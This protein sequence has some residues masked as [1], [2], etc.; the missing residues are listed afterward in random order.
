MR[1]GFRSLP[2]RITAAILTAGLIVSSSNLDYVR[3]VLPGVQNVSQVEAA[4]LTTGTIKDENLLKAMEVYVNYQKEKLNIAELNG[5]NLLSDGYSDYQKTITEEEARNFNGDVDL[6]GCTGI[7]ELTGIHIF[8][9]IKSINIS[10]Y[11]G[12]VISNFAFQN[13]SELNK[14]VIPNTVTSIGNFAFNNCTKL[15]TIEVKGDTVNN[16]DGILNLY[17]INIIGESAFSA[18]TKFE[19]VVFNQS[20]TGLK[21]GSN[22]FN[23]CTGLKSIYVPTKAAG[24]LG[25]GVFESCEN[26]EKATLNPDLTVIPNA[27]FHK[28]NLSKMDTFPTALERIGVDAFMHTS[29]LTPDLSACKKLS[30]IDQG[31]FQAIVYTPN[32]KTDN[33]FILPDNLSGDGAGTLAEGTGIRR[34][35]FFNSTL[36]KINIPSGITEIQDS[37]FEGCDYLDEVIIDKDNSK[38]TKINDWAFRRCVSLNNTDFISELPNLKEI[39]AYAFAECYYLEEKY[40]EDKKQYVYV[41]DNYDV[42]TPGGGLSRIKLPD[43]LEKIGNYAFANNYN[44]SEISMGNKITS[45]PDYAFSLRADTAHTLIAVEGLSEVLYYNLDQQLL[46]YAGKLKKVTLSN[47]LTDIGVGAFKYNTHLTTVTYNYANVK[48]DTLELPSSVVSIGNN[49]FS[50]CARWSAKDWDND[51]E[52]NY[53]IYGL[54]KIDLKDLKLQN[55]GEGVFQNDYMLESAILP[56]DLKAIPKK[57]FYV[58]ETEPRRIYKVTKYNEGKSDAYTVKS[59]EKIYGLNSVTFPDNVEEIG[60]S[61]FEGCENF[62]YSGEKYTEDDQSLDKLPETLKTIGNRAFYGCRRIGNIALNSN[63]TSIGNEAF[64]WCSILNLNPPQGVENTSFENQF[65]LKYISFKPAGSLSNIGN[66]AFSYTAIT[67][68]DMSN[69]KLLENI[70][71]SLFSNC[72]NLKSSLIP[73]NVTSV[74]ANVYNTNVSLKKV[75]LP[76][77][78]TVSTTIFAGTSA[79]TVFDMGITLSARN[80]DRLIRVPLNKSIKLNY[81]KLTPQKPDTS[82]EYIFVQ[83]VGENELKNDA[84]KFIR[85]SVDAQNGEVTL[86]GIKETEENSILSIT[87]NM[88]FQAKS[89]NKT[90][91]VTKSIHKDFDLTVSDVWAEKLSISGPKEA[92][93]EKDGSKVLSISAEKITDNDETNVMEVLASVEPSPLTKAPVWGTDSTDVITVDAIDPDDDTT[94]KYVNDNNLS[95]ARVHVKAGGTAK[96]WVADRN[97]SLQKVKDEVTVKVLYPVTSIETKVG[98]L[99]ADSNNYQLE[100]GSEDTIT[101]NPSYSDDGAK[102]GEESKAKI[103]FESS[104]PSVATIDRETGKV[105][106]QNKTGSTIIRVFDDTGKKLKDITIN[107]VEEGMLKPN[108]IK[109]T[110]EDRVDLYKDKESIKISAK[111]FPEKADQEVTW[112]VDNTDIVS[113]TNNEDGSVTLKGKTR[114]ETW[115]NAISK[116]SNNIRSRIL[117]SVALPATV[118]KFQKASAQVAVGAN[119]EIGLT[120]VEDDNLKLLYQ[121][122]EANKD[123]V[124]WTIEDNDIAEFVNVKDKKTLDNGVPIIKG[125][126]QGNTKLIA[127][128]GNGLS[129]FINISVFKPITEFSIQE[130]KSLHVKEQFKLDVSKKPDDSIENIIFTSSNNDILTVSEDGTVTGVAEGRASVYAVRSNGDRK[131][132]V[133]NVVN[134]VSQIEILDKPIELAIDGK[135]TIGKAKDA[136]DATNGYKLTPKSNDQPLWSSSDPNVAA[137]EVSGDNVTIKGVGAGKAEITATTLSGKTASISVTVV[138]T[139]TELKFTEETKNVAVGTQ[140]A[141]S[142][143]RTPVDSSET[144]VYKSSNEKIATVDDNGIVT[145]IEKGEVTITATSNV[146]KKSAGIK[147]IVTVPATKIQ[148][149]T[150]YASEKKIYLV[151]GN[152]YRLRYKILPEESTDKVTFTSNKKKIA[153]ISEDGTITAKKKGNATITI[154]T[155]SGKTAKVK[156]YVVNKEKN[157]KKIKIKTASIKVGK[158][159]KLK[160]T[161]TAATTTNSVGYSVDKPEIASIDEFGYITG[162]KKGKVKVTITMSNGKAK[163]KTIKVKK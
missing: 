93:E 115:L 162:L 94:V 50:D 31:A 51:G 111:V 131:E 24:D 99:E 152:T 15:S 54:G 64:M 87:N 72:Y 47:A 30:L 70:P 140:A 122:A 145:G 1:K 53:E 66:S 40:D 41:T 46:S 142:L 55:F 90:V 146:S 102:A 103:Y 25:Q 118:L 127:T 144:I 82:N 57:L 91:L 129:T 18:A 110:P 128:S 27:F 76:A 42:Y 125:L 84:D 136:A 19:G 141:L 121:P 60:D 34:I 45:I 88:K 21:L 69:N 65:G 71:D 155:E 67:S 109:I 96:L 133:V 73:E 156:V 37:V 12:T 116:T 89:N 126:K 81:I 97:D 4:D 14:I 38:L 61:S 33:K 151:K 123:S 154:K 95:K 13:C 157:A 143:N 120:T 59:I 106:A 62:V 163:T 80:D 138:N 5:K 108:L 78:A 114:G 107:V 9:R 158:T 132:C 74:G 8:Q 7:K 44:V 105:L 98:T 150:N 75:Q 119:L 113:L 148:A 49:A 139:I 86:T 63:L 153:P 35:A 147:V 22:A 6:S 26:L 124:K 20:N 39:G 85:D 161:V 79:S 48:E 2:A 137:V 117:V 23:S 100:K 101:V 83:K 104:D 160:Y 58:Q 11:S 149:V 134:P 17:N 43:S 29:L 112:S 130:K 159:V 10:N 3:F 77:I 16:K 135:Y 68:A 32:P 28:A 52:I 92:I 56:T 36:Q